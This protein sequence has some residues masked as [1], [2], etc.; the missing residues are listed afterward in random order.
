MSEFDTIGG[1][2]PGSTPADPADQ[3]EKD[4]IVTE[5]MD[6]LYTEDGRFN[7]AVKYL[8][9][10]ANDPVSALSGLTSLIMGQLDDTRDNNIAAIVVLPAA[11]E[12]LSE[13]A[14]IANNAGAFE[15]DEALVNA[16]SQMATARLGEEYGV[17][18]QDAEEMLQ[19]LDPQM[20][21]EV[22]KQQE[23]YAVARMPAN[24]GVPPNG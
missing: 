17:E 16:A 21:D 9:E 22:S 14:E 7:A 18:P 5:A 6:M 23:Q 4:E 13:L 2:I 12:V 11:M 15:V 1:E 19:G 10:G 3:L 8:K 24:P 20:L